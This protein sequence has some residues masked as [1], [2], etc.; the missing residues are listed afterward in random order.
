MSIKNCPT[1]SVSVIC[2][3]RILL[4]TVH[5]GAIPQGDTVKRGDGDSVKV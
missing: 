4:T 2:Q 5:L 1:V 3:F